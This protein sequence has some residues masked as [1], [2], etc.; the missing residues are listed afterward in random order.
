MYNEFYGF[1]KL[2]FSITPDPN[3]VYLSQSHREALAQMMY[4]IQ[5][6]KP[7]MAMTGEVGV[8]KTTMIFTLLSSFERD[9]LVSIIFDTHVDSKSLYRYIFADYR[10]PDKPTER[11][12]ATLILRDFLTERQQQGKK[13]ILILD[14]AHNLSKEILLEVVF[15]TNMETMQ[16]KLLQILLVGQPELN[17][18]LG[19]HE[20]R[21]LRQRVSLRTE[22][23]P[24]S[25][26][27]TRAYV[28]HRIKEAGRDDPATLFS[29]DAISAI[30]RLTKGIPR[31]INTLCDNTLLLG[32]ARKKAIISP[33][34]V[35]ETFKDM[36]IPVIEPP[37]PAPAETPVGVPSVDA[38]GDTV[39]SEETVDTRQS[40]DEE[41]RIVRRVVRMPDGSEVVKKVRQ[42]RRLKGE[43]AERKSTKRKVRPPLIPLPEG[44]P[45]ARLTPSAQEDFLP[46]FKHD[47]PSAIRQYHLLWSRIDNLSEQ[48]PVHSLIVTSSLP[49]EGKSITSI[50]LAATIAH[51]PDVRVLLIDADMHQPKTH[52]YLGLTMPNK[53]L[54][55]ILTGKA[56]FMDCLINFEMERLFYI[57]AGVT[58]GAP[59]ELLVSSAID[60]LLD[61]VKGYF[62][63]III[64]S[65]PLVPI[66]D[67]VGLAGKVDGVLLVVRARETSRKI[68]MQALDDLS[69]KRVIG[70]VL[71]DLDYKLAGGRYAHGG[72]GYGGY[73]YGY[74]YPKSPEKKAE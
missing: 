44:V 47:H 57:P 17:N 35:K 18:I 7:L 32:Y 34:L 42:I 60:H 63:Y 28:F 52:E 71:N 65:P 61:E 27:D 40:D 38:S 15:L 26:D 69:E 13:S 2:P 12:D 74:G 36:E 21:Q 1:K 16:N 25:F 14:E 20:F 62:H 72:Y 56:T 70:V 5:E 23:K 31:L 50:N 19:S 24:L 73:G 8:G 46:A 29:E 3:F 11:A 10:I 51:T 64:D 54:T 33:D 37:K 59:T 49:R 30:F 67:T 41:V 45:L 55:D 22:I 9:S 68:I 4:G 58:E 39:V 43:G 66:A 48:E 6:R 53:G